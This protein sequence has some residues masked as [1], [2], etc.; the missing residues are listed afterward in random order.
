[1]TDETP[2]PSSDIDAPAKGAA[3]EHTIPKARLDQ[4]ISKRTEA[5]SQMAKMADAIL[6]EVPEA[7]RDLIPEGLPPA[8]RVAWVQKAKAKGIFGEAAKQPAPE[9]PA[10]DIGKPKTQA[11]D[12]D[13][14]D[15][16]PSE[17]MALGYQK[18]G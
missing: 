9:V 7:F 6:A 8:D 15:L 11:P 4:E 17:R 18:K 5:E 1:M 3:T 12:V 2:A 16:P 13:L 14:W 10:T